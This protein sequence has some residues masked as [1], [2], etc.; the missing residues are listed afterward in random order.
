MY[1]AITIG[2]ITKNPVN[3]GIGDRAG[4]IPALQRILRHS[5]VLWPDADLDPVST[6][7]VFL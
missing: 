3:P 2:R 5:W 4:I 7:R 6:I 1:G